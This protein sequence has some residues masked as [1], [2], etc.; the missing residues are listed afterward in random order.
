M[1]A[2]HKQT[3][4][5]L[6]SKQLVE[7]EAT[8]VEGTE[9]KHRNTRNNVL[10]EQVDVFGGHVVAHSADQLVN[11]LLF[12]AVRLGGGV[13]GPTARVLAQ[14]A[15]LVFGQVVLWIKN[16]QRSTSY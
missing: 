1:I 16:K 7:K 15:V 13:H 10:V 4:F 3:E 14:A 9:K 8:E 6:H 5:S 2:K 11:A 12:A